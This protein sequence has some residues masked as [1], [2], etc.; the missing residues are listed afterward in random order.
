M[1]REENFIGFINARASHELIEV[2]IRDRLRK[3]IVLGEEAL[4]AARR[5][6]PEDI[7]I[8]EERL[9]D[10][11]EQLRRILYL[12]TATVGGRQ[13]RNETSNDQV[14]TRGVICPTHYLQCL[15]TVLL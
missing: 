9:N 13:T 7:P 5:S 8:I 1:P 3:Y 15:G 6:K 12:N 4:I 11:R 10:A 14:N 2:L